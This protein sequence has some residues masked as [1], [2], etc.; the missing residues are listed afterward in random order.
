MLLELQAEE[1]TGYDSTLKLSGFESWEAEECVPDDRAGLRPS[2]VVQ[3][4]FLSL[5][6]NMPV[7][8]SSLHNRRT[9]RR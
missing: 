8:V 2:E 4:K 5:M 7:P 6:P 9:T 1:M 3:Q